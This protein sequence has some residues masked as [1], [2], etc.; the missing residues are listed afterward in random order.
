MKLLV[1]IVCHLNLFL[2]FFFF[3]GGG[4]GICLFR[5]TCYVSCRVCDILSYTGW[6]T[7][8]SCSEYYFRS[9]SLDLISDSAVS[10]WCFSACPQHQQ[11]HWGHAT[12]WSCECEPQT[13]D[14]IMMELVWVDTQSLL[15]CFY[16]DVSQWWQLHGAWAMREILW[17][18]RLNYLLKWSCVKACPEQ[19]D[20]LRT[21]KN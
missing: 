4:G 11:L 21:T 7:P 16:T 10:V 18:V 14:F 19:S 2:F 1:W 3:G 13:G 15:A 17:I 20:V 5:P 12:V 8:C 6:Q 9:V